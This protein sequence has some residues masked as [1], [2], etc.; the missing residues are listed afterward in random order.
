M[1]DQKRVKLKLEKKRGMWCARGFDAFGESIRISLGIPDT[2]SELDAALE[3]GSFKAKIIANGGHRLVG[4]KSKALTFNDLADVYLEK[5]VIPDE[6]GRI[7]RVNEHWKL[8]AV[9]AIDESLMLN[10]ERSMI[11]R[12]LKP[13]T[14]KR[15]QNT[16]KA[17]LNYGCKSMKLPHPFLPVIGSDS[18]PRVL[19]MPNEDRDKIMG[20][21]P[22]DHVWF[23]TA[24]AYTGARPCELIALLWRDVDI[25]NQRITL[26]SYKNKDGQ[27]KSRTIPIGA[28]VAE[29]LKEL[30]DRFNCARND[31]VF[32]K[33]DGSAWADI[34]APTNGVMKQFYKAVKLAG[35][36][37]GVDAAKTLY[38]FRHTFGTNAGNS[39][40]L[41]PMVLSVYMGHKNVQTTKDNYFHGGVSDADMLVKGLG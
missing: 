8:I 12:K 35:F 27:P 31:Y 2:E 13:S 20:C 32:R 34:K 16:F 19:V 28:K 41:N 21:M 24:L 25:E 15:Y 38:T 26:R 40:D 9:S 33:L 17:V 3:L 1:I 11:A 7:K 36:E 5:E 18:E 6:V 23:F 30:M 37:S 4:A 10:W 14:I 22:E 39:G 29:V